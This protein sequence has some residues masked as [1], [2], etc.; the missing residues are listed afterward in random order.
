MLKGLIPVGNVNAD[1]LDKLQK[2]KNLTFSD[3]KD[4]LN[5]S[6]PDIQGDFEKKLNEWGIGLTNSFNPDKVS[7]KIYDYLEKHPVPKGFDLYGLSFFYDLSTENSAL[8]LNGL[9]SVEDV[10]PK[11]AGKLQKNKG[12]TLPGFKKSLY[13]LMDEFDFKAT[14]IFADDL[15]E[16]QSLYAQGKYHSDFFNRSDLEKSLYND[17]SKFDK[18]Y[19]GFH[20]YNNINDFLVVYRKVESEAV[21]VDTSMRKSELSAE[22]ILSYF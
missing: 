4:I 8:M 20:L 6:M 12:I 2:S 3:F 16:L 21:I 13:Y 15:K 22:K 18:N 14:L 11:S 19:T 10:K 17:P 7:G 1:S 9:T 5:L